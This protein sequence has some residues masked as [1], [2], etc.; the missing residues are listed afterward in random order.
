ML[1]VN[2]FQTKQLNPERKH[3]VIHMISKELQL[4]ISGKS[5]SFFSF[6]P[7]KILIRISHE[8]CF[9]SVVKS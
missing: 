6:L 9:A 5:Q 2:R 4:N 1:T 3:N 7:S 8:I